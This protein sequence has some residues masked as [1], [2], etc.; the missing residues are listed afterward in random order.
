LYRLGRIKSGEILIDN[1]SIYNYSREVYASNVSGVYQKPFVFEMSIR[2]NLSLIDS[3]V[4]HQIEVCKRV[5]IHDFIQSLPKGYNTIIGE[6]AYLLTDGHKQLLAVARSLLSKSEILL[7][8]E[9]TSN[10]DPSYTAKFVELLLDLKSDH[11]IILVTHKSEMM[12]IADKVVVLDNG[13]VVA[14]GTNEE[15]IRKSTLYNDLKNR[16]FASV[17]EVI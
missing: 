15:V 16:T 13:K 3:N 1:E 10:I 14:K 5:G 17:S 12:E 2:D 11:T 6:E 4:K 8:D 7:L 9:V